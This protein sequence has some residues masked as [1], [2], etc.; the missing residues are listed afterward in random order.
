VRDRSTRYGRIWGGC[1]GFTLVEL[2]VVVGI[3]AL[4]LAVLLPALV[5]AQRSARTLQCASNV[6]QISGALLNYA[7][8]NDGRF[9]VNA[10]S[11][12]WYAAST[13]GPYLTDKLLEWN[14]SPMQAPGVGGGVL[15]CPE[16]AV[17][18]AWRSYAMNIW[19]SSLVDNVAAPPDRGRIWSPHNR[20]GSSMIL[21]TE[22]W[23]HNQFTEA[24]GTRWFYPRPT[25][26]AASQYPGDRFGAGSGLPMP[27][28]VKGFATTTKVKGEL[29]FYR[30]RSAGQTGTVVSPNGR[31]NIGYGDGHVALK[32]LEE[33]A[34]PV[35]GR[36]TFDSLWSPI[37]RDIERPSE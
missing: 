7:A 8:D 23:C 29:T 30:H 14:G 2:L 12:F 22:G 10:G 25:V 5:A 11:R 31:I 21:V 1:R 26:G 6:R 15:V 35:D 37:D 28:S 9:P 16:D 19:A 32:S 27:M 24:S 36:S 13:I 17:D 34:D 3:V 4:L 20:Q 33:L 18:G